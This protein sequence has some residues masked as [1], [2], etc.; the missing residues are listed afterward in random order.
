MPGNSEYGYAHVAPAS[1]N[2]GAGA[3][4]YAAGNL[5]GAIAAGT[6]I[7]D[8]NVNGITLDALRQKGWTDAQIKADLNF[9]VL[10]PADAPPPPINIPDAPAT[11]AITPEVTEEELPDGT[12]IAESDLPF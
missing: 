5:Q 1:W 6:A 9:R 10:L 2:N 8:P 3:N 11:E 12:K 7:P 4:A